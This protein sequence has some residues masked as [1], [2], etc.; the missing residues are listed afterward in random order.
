MARVGQWRVGIATPEKNGQST[1][2]ALRTQRRERR[3]WR[4]IEAHGVRTLE[5]G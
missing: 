2:E 1:A 5:L 4:R 3:D